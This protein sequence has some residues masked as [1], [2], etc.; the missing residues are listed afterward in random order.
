[1]PSITISE[2][3]LSTWWASSELPLRQM[4]FGIG[5]N[6]NFFKL[7]FHFTDSHLGVKNYLFLY[8][9]WTHGRTIPLCST[10]FSRS[11]VEPPGLLQTS[12][13]QQDGLQQGSWPQHECAP[14]TANFTAIILIHFTCREQHHIIFICAAWMSKF[15]IWTPK[16]Q[17]HRSSH[18][19]FVPL[20]GE[21]TT[22][23]V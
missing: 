18:P 20:G 19:Y 8:L 23:H 7:S 11:I 9:G 1:M 4:Y 22:H 17:W 3:I 15:S 2:T 10:D 14:V 12:G 6:N 16:P 21:Q 5:W 13:N